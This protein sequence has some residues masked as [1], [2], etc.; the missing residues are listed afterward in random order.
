MR[1]MLKDRED[2]GKQL[3]ERV[4]HY[5]NEPHLIVLG[6]PRGGVVTAYEVAKAL[7]APMDIIVTRKIGAPFNP[8][9]A[10]GAVTDQG[11]VIYDEAAMKKLN[12]SIDTL[13]DKA[14]EEK[15][16]AMRRLDLYRG[17]RPALDLEGKA[18]ILVDDGVAT[19]LTMKAAILSVRLRGAKKVIVAVPVLPSDSREDLRKHVDDVQYVLMP[20]V[21]YSISQFY[22]KFPQKSDEEIIALLDTAKKP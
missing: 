12:L 9:F 22:E 3:A 20:E 17:D 4:L 2:G 11:T 21:F 18:V 5:K 10:V 14:E 15:K 1:M 6:L 13:D 19:G 7:D 8:E 16:E